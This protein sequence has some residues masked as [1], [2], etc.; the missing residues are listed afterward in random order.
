M[1]HDVYF[2]AKL[3]VSVEKGGRDNNR[4]VQGVIQ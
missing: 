2:V 1:Q 3:F 4:N